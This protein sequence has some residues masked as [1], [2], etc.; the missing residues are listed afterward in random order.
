MNDDGNGGVGHGDSKE[1]NNLNSDG[2]K[3]LKLAE[4]VDGGS[5]SG[6]SKEPETCAVCLDDICS[7]DNLVYLICNHAFHVDC[8][9]PWFLQK[10]TLC[11]LCKKDTLEG[12]GLDRHKSVEHDDDSDDD[13]DEDVNA[14]R[15]P[16]TPSPAAAALPGDSSQVT[17]SSQQ[18]QQQ[19]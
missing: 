9:R 8:A 10:S 6:S 15:A 16:E 3:T 7:G 5:S 2:H 11:P 4:E 17:S 14:E 18:Q 1:N 12:L 19:Q 13:D